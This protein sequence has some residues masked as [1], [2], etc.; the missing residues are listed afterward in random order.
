M[1]E[2]VAKVRSGLAAGAC[3][4]HAKCTFLHRLT[5]ENGPSRTS[6]RALGWA[7]LGGKADVLRLGRRGPGLTRSGRSCC[8]DTHVAQRFNSPALSRLAP[9][10]RTNQP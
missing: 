4:R 8:T 9:L 7:A 5:A 6:Q 3:R 10:L 1:P 2:I